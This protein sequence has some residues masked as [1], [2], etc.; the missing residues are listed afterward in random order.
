MKKILFVIP[1]MAA[2]TV[3]GTTL[4]D[5]PYTTQMWSPGDPFGFTTLSNA[6][7]RS[8][9]N[10]ARIGTNDLRISNNSNRIDS[11]FAV[12][13]TNETTTAIALATKAS[14]THTNDA[15]AHASLFSSY[16]PI[17]SWISWLGT[18]TYVKTELDPTVPDH[19]KSITQEQIASWSTPKD[20]TVLASSDSNLF[21][22]ISATNLVMCQTSSG[23]FCLTYEPETVYDSMLRS[24]PFPNPFYFSKT[25]D[26]TVVT[27]DGW[28]IYA[29]HD[30]SDTYMTGLDDSFWGDMLEPTPFPVT[31]YP[32]IGVPP[33][34]GS[35][36][37]SYD[38]LG[39]TN[40]LKVFSSKADIDSAIAGLVS[41]NESRNVRLS[42][43]TL[44]DVTKSA[45]PAASSGVPSVW[46]NMLWG[47]SGT[48]STYRMSWDVTNGTFK[49]EEILP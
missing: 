48:N 18:N 12:I 47:A 15:N 8:I 14:S 5:V 17:T 22:R 6:N 1:F 7:T 42:S 19:I 13:E 33:T 4:D 26:V 35:P 21:V 44:G 37:L 2:I 45:W 16:L 25:G 3:F 29:G 41:T 49:V 39:G 32:Y 38:P 34:Y 28:T 10:A 27:L 11:V 43:L 9:S 36:V 46:T 31:L 30:T 24:I 20:G 23:L 40:V